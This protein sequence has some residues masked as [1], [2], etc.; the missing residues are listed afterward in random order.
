M[1]IFNP[2]STDTE[3]LPAM[4]YMVGPGKD[5]QNCVAN[6]EALPFSRSC[7][8]RENRDGKHPTQGLVGTTGTD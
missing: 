3:V 1:T 4:K 5:V 7:A 8:D 2:A 6:P